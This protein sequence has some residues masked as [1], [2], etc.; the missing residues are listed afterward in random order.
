MDRS[1]A[2][3]TRNV[4]SATLNEVEITEAQ[5]RHALDRLGQVIVNLKASREL[6][7]ALV[8]AID[9]AARS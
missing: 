4:L 8:R 1:D 5:L 7:S 3:A 2:I 9:V 6:L